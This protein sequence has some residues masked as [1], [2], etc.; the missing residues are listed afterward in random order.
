MDKTDYE[1]Y[2]TSPSWRVTRNR[3][4]K[5]AGWKC[6]RC[7][8]RRGLQVHHLTYERLGRELDTD[9]EVL[10]EDCHRGH[11][12]DAMHDQPLSRLYLQLASDV[13]KADPFAPVAEIVAKVKDECARLRLPNDFVAIDKAV[14]VLIGSGRFKTPPPQTREEVIAAEGRPLTHAEAKDCL[15]RLGFDVLIKAMPSSPVS[16]IDIYGPP[17]EEDFSYEV[18]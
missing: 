8:Q 15:R 7:P 16:K 18:F 12:L 13:V 6:N 2:L 11:H 10:C 5:Q 3:A 14:N 1:K 4:L 9:L 17:P